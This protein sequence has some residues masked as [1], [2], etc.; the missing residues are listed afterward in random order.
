MINK[1]DVKTVIELASK[2]YENCWEMLAELKA[3]NSKQ[4][5]PDGLLNFQSMLCKVMLNLEK[6]YLSISREKKGLV[7][8]KAYLTNKWF[9]QRMK[10]LHDYQVA[11]EKCTYIGKSLGNSFVWIFYRNEGDLLIEHLKHEEISHLPTGIGGIGELGFITN[12]KRIGDCFIIY[13]GIT[14]ILRHGDI[15][16]YDIKKRKIIALGDLKTKPD[17]EHCVLVKILLVGLSIKDVNSINKSIHIS[18]P[19]ELPR[20]GTNDVI[21]TLPSQFKE[22]LSRQ[23]SNMSSSLIERE[24]IS[25]FEQSSF[26][27]DNMSKLNQIYKNLKTSKFVYEIA[28][29]SLLLGAY[30]NPTQP[31]S[32]KLMG[33]AEV[34]QVKFKGIEEKITSILDNTRSDNSLY[35]SPFYY[36]DDGSIINL[37][38]TV[39]LFWWP[40]DNELIKA[41]IF[42]DVII[43]TLF[44]P[45]HLIKKLEVMGFKTKGNIRENT[46]SL[47]KEIGRLNL[48]VEQCMFFI[49]LIQNNLLKEES[50]VDIINN[51]EKTIEG[52]TSPNNARNVIGIKLQQSFISPTEMKKMKEE[53]KKQ[54]KGIL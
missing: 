30:K 47:S 46:F 48:N 6:V 42:Y 10:S 16:L 23:L 54:L 52:Q 49:R 8:R 9:L 34:S 29:P 22:R 41:I 14:T 4:D 51:I 35:F 3:F 24:K 20:T 39:P 28:D 5:F 27:D 38:G 36:R 26:I 43:F 50:V 21:T 31:L 25:S 45:L 7:A 13:H 12:I 32:S 17:G 44:N 40:L 53:N 33:R 2:T 18:S 19:K 37:P 1:N 15:S 11:I